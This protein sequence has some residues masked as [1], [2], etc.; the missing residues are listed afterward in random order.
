MS[1]SAAPGTEPK[2]TLIPA[3]AKA[4]AKLDNLAVKLQ[5]LE[6]AVQAAAGQ[7]WQRDAI[8]KLAESMWDFVDE[9]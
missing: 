1:T 9:S 6:L 5:I 4:R 2:T 8:M 3:G 7:N